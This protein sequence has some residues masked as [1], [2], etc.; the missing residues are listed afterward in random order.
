[1]ESAGQMKQQNDKSPRTGRMLSEAF[2]EVLP[3]TSLGWQIAGT[4][5][6]AFAI[7]YGLDLWLSTTPYLTV[8]FAV[9]GIAGSIITFL[10]MAESLTKRNTNKENEPGNTR[11]S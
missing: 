9:L 5:L 1:M 4:L 2:R 7:G 6:A 11:T 3:Y 10:R 8:T